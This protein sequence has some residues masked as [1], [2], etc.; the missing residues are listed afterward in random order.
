MVPFDIQTIT[1]L[2]AALQHVDAAIELF[3]A[4]KYAPAVT[5]AAAAEGCLVRPA[6]QAVDATGDLHS[7]ASETAKSLI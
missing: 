1:K 3:Y 2:G 5:L 7:G 4:K 6:D